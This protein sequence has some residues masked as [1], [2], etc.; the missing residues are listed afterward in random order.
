VLGVE[1]ILLG[2]DH[3]LFVLGLL[4]I[5]RNGWALVKTITAFTAAHSITL[6]LAALGV[7]EAPSAAVDVVV[8]LSIMFLGVEI[9]HAQRG[10]VGLTV[11]FP[12]LVAFGFGLVHGLGF[13]GAL[14]ALGLPQREIPVAL[15]FFNVGVEVGQLMFVVAFLAWRW[16]LRR[17]E[18][19]FPIW[20]KPVP[21]YAIG[22]V[23]TYWFAGRLSVLF[24]GSAL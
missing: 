2:I 4:F 14:N 5:V 8:A 7:V 16:A 17:L 13:A 19:R 12:W 15:F 11:R 18:V 1:H 6:G 9:V 23:A 22:I 3:L 10:R 21:A 20:T 24:Q